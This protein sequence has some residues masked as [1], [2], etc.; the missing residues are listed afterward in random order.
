MASGRP[1]AERHDVQIADMDLLLAQRPLKLPRDPLRIPDLLRRS[2]RA[3]FQG[4]KP[5][6]GK[7]SYRVWSQ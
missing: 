5:E 2:L 1:G 6:E 3:R 7:F 4:R